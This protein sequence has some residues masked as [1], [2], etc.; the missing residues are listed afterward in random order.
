MISLKELKSAAKDFLAFAERQKDVKEAEAYISCNAL[1]V[2]RIA[3]H[4]KIPS[5][6]LEEPKSEEDYGLSLRILFK[7]GRN[8]MGSSDSNLSTEG[9][10][11][12]YSK[13]Y[14]ARVMDTDFHSLPEA[15][16]KARVGKFFDPRIMKLD[17]GKGIAKAYEMLDGAFGR[18]KKSHFSGGI[19]ITGELDLTASRFCVMSTNGIFGFEENTGSLATLTTSLEAEENATGTSFESSTHI[20]RLDAH[21]AGIESAEKAL[22]MQ[23][24]KSIG[25][26][27]Y[28]VVL[29]ESV[30]AELLYSRFDVALS[31][32]DYNASPFI[33][34][35]GQKVGVEQLS[36]SDD[37][38]LEGIIGSK[39]VSDEGRQAR[40]TELVRNGVLVNY[41]S[42]DY[43]TKKKPEWAKFLP[44]NGFRSGTSRS[45][46][47]DVGIH[48]TNIVVGKGAYSRE[49]LIEEV[50]NGV[51]VGRM[52]YTY[53]VNG[54]AS[55]DYTGTIRGDSCLIENGRI[56]GA[57]T[58]NSMRVI[59]NI[60][61]LMKNI[62]GIGK[63][64][65]AV[66]SW[67][68]E[69]TIVT[70]EIALSELNMKRISKGAY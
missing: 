15:H 24:P 54:H 36:V 7:D 68:Q 20:S 28:R 8:G 62:I 63:K 58:P 29:S 11:E 42:N 52:W 21:A 67:G 57:L 5:N 26:G 66:Q 19:N 9:F 6:G 60:D 38:G 4:S 3:Y 25:S 46:D 43:Y 65:K 48:G 22:S 61:N 33:G 1:N 39:A 41:L 30:V 2:Y 69:E 10:R 55:P 12:A 40:K 44:N 17:E 27:K 49:E 59:D 45:Y 32:I 31:S 53:P 64:Q 34:R 50:K 56:A 13:A 14:D 51:Y 23:N 47:S 18:L 37:P 70:P 35:I 16:G